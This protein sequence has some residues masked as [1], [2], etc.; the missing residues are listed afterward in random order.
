[1]GKLAGKWTASAVQNKASVRLDFNSETL[2]NRDIGAVADK[3][4]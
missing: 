3:G 4:V 1:M 2:V